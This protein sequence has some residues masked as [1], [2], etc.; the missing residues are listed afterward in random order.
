ML[1]LWMLSRLTLL[2]WADLSFVLPVTSLGYVLAALM[3]K[4]F[5]AEEVSWP[6]W[7]GTLLIVAGIALVGATYPRTTRPHGGG[8]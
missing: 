3:G 5:L 6:R 2:S 1:I 7:A 8:R 4:L